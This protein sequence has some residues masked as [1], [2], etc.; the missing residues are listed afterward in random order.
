MTDLQ[1]IHFAPKGFFSVTSKCDV[2][3][4]EL[5]HDGQIKCRLFKI[6]F[7]LEDHHICSCRAFCASFYSEL[8]F[9]IFD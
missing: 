5:Q 8:N 3:Y 7:S 6:I 1:K 4:W 2:L 9:L